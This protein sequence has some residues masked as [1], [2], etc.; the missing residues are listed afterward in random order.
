MHRYKCMLFV[1][2]YAF[3]ECILV[4]EDTNKISI[5]VCLLASHIETNWNK[6]GPCVYITWIRLVFSGEN[7]LYYISYKP[8]SNISTPW[9]NLFFSTRP[10]VKCIV[11]ACDAFHICANESVKRRF[12][13]LSVLKFAHTHTDLAMKIEGE[14]ETAY[15]ITI[16]QYSIASHALQDIC[17]KKTKTRSVAARSNV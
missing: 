14:R 8:E 1:C 6:C 12:L 11:H 3:G 7:M 13:F 9:L 16:L 2:V 10:K 17:P 5:L 15:L 4:K